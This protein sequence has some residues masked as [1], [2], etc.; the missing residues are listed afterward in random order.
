MRSKTMAVCSAFLAI[1]ASQPGCAA[2]E[3]RAAVA[4]PLP[5][6]FRV[7][8]RGVDA[9]T[10][11][12]WRIFHTACHSCHGLGGVGTDV[13]PNL[14]ERIERYTP[15]GFATK[16]LTSY[17]IVPG[18]SD[19]TADERAAER[20]ALLEQLM[21]RERAATGQ[22]LMPAWETDAKVPPHV[23][24]LYAY[25]TA[26]AAGLLGPGR[27]ALSTGPVMPGPTPPR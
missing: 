13:A 1:L 4:E 17:R 20:Q 7:D 5:G 26:R 24:D 11:T 19:G 22:V 25:L 10:Y 27:P 2:P 12:G 15:R 9:G 14:V 6:E 16:V 23:L 21:R 18:L 3:K 8:A